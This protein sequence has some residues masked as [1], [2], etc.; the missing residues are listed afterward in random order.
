MNPATFETVDLR[1]QR[2]ID[3]YR[4]APGPATKE[5]ESFIDFK[6]TKRVAKGERSPNFRGT[7]IFNSNT[8]SIAPIS[9]RFETYR[10][11]QIP[12]LF[13]EFART[14][15][16]SEGMLAF[17]NTFGLPTGPGSPRTARYAITTVDLLLREHAKMRRAFNQLERGDQSELIKRQQELTPLQIQLVQQTDGRL[18]FALTPPDLL[19]AMWYQ[20]ALHACDG[21]KLFTCERCNKP[22]IVGSGTKRRS[23][24]KYCSPACGNAAWRASHKS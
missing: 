19:S 23:T 9:K 1:W 2:C 20:L 4:F 21:T 22:F 15:S 24:A 3:G 14:A 16:T 8:G 11:L 17:C 12:A 18:A 10:P 6:S 7:A 5:I 13:A